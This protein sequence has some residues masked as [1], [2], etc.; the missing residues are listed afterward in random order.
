[1]GQC[2][3]LSM[4]SF[5]TIAIRVGRRQGPELQS[6]TGVKQGCPFSPL[7]FGLLAD[8]LHACLQVLANLA[9]ACGACSNADG[10]AVADNVVI[11]DFGYADN[12]CLVSATADGLQRLLDATGA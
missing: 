2:L 3:R 6:L 5:A 8:G 1:M 9:R 10:T 4:Y 12:S 7:L 11:T